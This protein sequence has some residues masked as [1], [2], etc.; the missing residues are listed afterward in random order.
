M[1]LKTTF[2]KYHKYYDLSRSFCNYEKIADLDKIR[3]IFNNGLHDMREKEKEIVGLKED[4]SNLQ[5]ELEISEKELG[6]LKNKF[7]NYILIYGYNEECYDYYAAEDVLQPENV[8]ELTSIGNDLNVSGV[9]F[10][11]YSIGR[12]NLS[13][14]KK[15]YP[16]VPVE[17][18]EIEELEFMGY[19]KRNK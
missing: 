16:N 8:D 4:K 14:V 11:K 9:Y 7:K 12:V 2:V 5:F 18:K 19:M 6:K 15:C 3:N 13:K 10:R 17:E 1:A